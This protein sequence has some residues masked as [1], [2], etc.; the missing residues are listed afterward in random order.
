MHQKN[1]LTKKSNLA[2]YIGYYLGMLRINMHDAKTNLSKYVE[3]VEDGEVVQLCRR[4]VPVAEI[5][6]IES[7][8]ARKKRKI[9]LG[10][11][12]FG[13]W[14]MP[15]SFWDPLPDEILAAFEGRS[16]RSST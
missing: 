4:N 5:R 7:E 6:K 12:L 8:P 9:G 16:G 11:E 13:P 3:Q 1:Y 10:K 2:N 15:D 14:E